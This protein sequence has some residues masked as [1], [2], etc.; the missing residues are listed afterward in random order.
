ME[1]REP[2]HVARALQRWRGL[3]VLDDCDAARHSGG[4]LDILT[5]LTSTQELSK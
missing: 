4:L 3:L 1:L 2:Q 5:K